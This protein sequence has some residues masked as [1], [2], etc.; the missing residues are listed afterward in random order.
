MTTRYL[1][2]VSEYEGDSFIG[3]VAS[4]EEVEAKQ[5]GSDYSQSYVVYIITEQYPVQRIYLRLTSDF[6]PPPL[7]GELERIFW[8]DEKGVEIREVSRKEALNYDIP[9]PD[10]FWVRE[11]GAIG[12]ITD[13]GLLR[14]GGIGTEWQSRLVPIPPGIMASGQVIVTGGWSL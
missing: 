7:R 8:E 4:L 12:R 3:E 13:D 2:F 10:G 5:D 14:I 9:V 1:L 6:L 11:Y